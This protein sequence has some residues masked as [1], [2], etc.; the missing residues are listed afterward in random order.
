MQ[1]LVGLRGQTYG[2][3]GVCSGVK[4]LLGTHRIF[5]YIASGVAKFISLD[6]FRQDYMGW[7]LIVF[8]GSSTQREHFST[9]TRFSFWRQQGFTENY[10][11]SF[12]L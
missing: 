5:H 4:V 2:F 8:P 9:S 12:L 6:V 7:F 3:G 1:D 10:T 11:Q